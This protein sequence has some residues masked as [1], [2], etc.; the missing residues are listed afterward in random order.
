MQL[1]IEYLIVL[2]N[3][4]KFYLTFKQIPNFITNI[5]MDLLEEDGVSLVLKIENNHNN[6]A[7]SCKEKW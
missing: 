3:G 2:F 7:L 6:L 4:N 1:I 5:L